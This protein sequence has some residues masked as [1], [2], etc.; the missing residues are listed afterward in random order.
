MEEVTNEMMPKQTNIQTNQVKGNQVADSVGG[1]VKDRVRAAA[2][3]PP[4][5]PQALQLSDTVPALSFSASCDM[6]FLYKAL[7]SRG[8]RKGP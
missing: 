6:A 7:C 4:A 8:L 3:S 2:K 5:S 1:L